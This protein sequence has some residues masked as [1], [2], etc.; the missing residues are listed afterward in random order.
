MSYVTV[1]TE[2]SAGIR[3]YYEDHVSGQPV[4]LIHGYLL[5]GHFWERQQR[6]LP[7][8]GYRLITHDGRGFGQ[9]SQPSA[10][11]DHDTVAADLNP[12]LEHLDLT[13]LVKDRYAYLQGLLDN[14]Y[15][16]DRLCRHLA[17]RLP[18]R[19]AQDRR[20]SPGGARRRGPDP[21]VPGPCGPAARPERR[22]HAGHRRRRPSQHRL[23]H[24]DE[25]STALLEFLTR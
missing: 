21:A 15:N 5:N 4:V 18:G 16:T 7:Q 6:V 10:G 9:S 11:Y 2:N 25:V 24:P 1:G 3:I 14:F 17:N 23:D 8:A 22:R 20:T 12:L 13:G 19:P